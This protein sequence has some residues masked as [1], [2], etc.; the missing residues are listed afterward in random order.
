MPAVDRRAAVLGLLTVLAA[1]ALFLAGLP[2]ILDALLS[3]DPFYMRLAALPAADLARQDPTWGPLYAWWLKPLR[4]AFGDPLAVNAANVVAL[5]LAVT[6]ALY[7]YVLVLTRRAAV[8]VGAALA[9]LI[10]DFNLPLEGKMSAFAL[11]VLLVGLTVAARL[12]SGPR[13]LSLAA[14]ASGL[15][16]YARPELYP[17]ALALAAWALWQARAAP[18]ERAW[19]LTVLLLIGGAAAAVGMPVYGSGGGEPRLLIAF[20]E[21][22]AWNWARWHDAVDY[23][24]AW[25]GAFGPAGSLHAA[26]LANPAAVLLHVAINAVRTVWFLAATTFVHYPLLVPANAPRLAQAENLA[27]AALGLG[28]LATT[29]RALRLRHGRT[30]AMYAVIAAGP[31]AAAVAIYP[32]AHYLLVPAVLLGVAVALA[33]A[34]RLPAGL[35]ASPRAGL[36]A[37]LLCLAAMPRPFVL[38]LAPARPGASVVGRVTV[39]RPVHDT[40]AFIR[41]LRLTPPVRVLTLTDGLGDLLGDGFQ[42]LKAWQVDRPL[43]RYLDERGIDLIVSFEPG[44]HSFMLPD[45]Y[46]PKLQED[47][48]AAGF[49]RLTVPNVPEVSLYVR[50]T[51]VPPAA[52]STPAASPLG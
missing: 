33:A 5:S 23:R 47:P 51:L 41:G 18:R 22:F 25:H 40:V 1:N 49:V 27:A 19:P 10:S 13:R 8:A 26:L 21:H 29:R 28:L 9:Y 50:S 12:P 37:A 11:L 35:L 36:L 31:I 52:R 24:T 39:T 20:R 46:W 38:P 43:A 34:E 42:E 16:G 17:A 6:L 4:A 44:K 7:A 30:L 15:A 14:A 48:A 2:T 3:M 45:Q 32:V